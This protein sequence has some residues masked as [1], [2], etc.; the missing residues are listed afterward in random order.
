MK[1]AEALSRTETRKQSGGTRHAGRSRAERDAL[2]AASGFGLQSLQARAEKLGART[3]GD[4]PSFVLTTT[5]EAA[6]LLGRPVKQLE[7]WRAR[8]LGPRFV[9]RGRR[10]GYPLGEIRRFASLDG[11]AE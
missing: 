11:A 4:L 3:I 7:A 8:G 2:S 10:I 9:R 1:N 5:V 6:L